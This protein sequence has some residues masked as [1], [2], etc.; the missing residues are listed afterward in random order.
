MK[1]PWAMWQYAH[2]MTASVVTASFVMASIGAFYLLLGQHR[3]FGE[4]FVRIGV[5]C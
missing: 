2:N 5:I 4:T 3:R 1:N